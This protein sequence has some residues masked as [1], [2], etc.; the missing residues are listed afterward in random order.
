MYPGLAKGPRSNGC[1]FLGPLKNRTFVASLTSVWLRR[2]FQG[3]T[4]ERL[5]SVAI[6]F[7]RTVILRASDV[8]SGPPLHG[9][10]QPIA[11]ACCDALESQFRG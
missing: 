7:Q 10:P 5:R 2:T 8:N 9:L 6:S 1:E 3:V 11:I 4:V